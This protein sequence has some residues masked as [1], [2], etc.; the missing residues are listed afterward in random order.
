MSESVNFE[1]LLT[2]EQV[3]EFDHD[4]DKNFGY[5]RR[6]ML[7][8]LTKSGDELMD[9]FAKQPDLVDE[10]NQVIVHFKSHVDVLSEMVAA[11]EYR[12]GVVKQSLDQQNG[13]L[14][15]Q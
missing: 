1:A 4:Y 8:V 3:F 13:S 9:G 7:M 10:M 6:V 12:L 15:I 14:V 5:K 11:A 2:P